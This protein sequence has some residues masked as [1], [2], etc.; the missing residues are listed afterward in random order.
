MLD[1]ILRLVAE[2]GTIGVAVIAD[3]LDQSP[4]LVRSALEE[5]AR[6][7]YLQVVAT[8]CAS[9]CTGCPSSSACLFGNQP[10]IWSLTPKGG[11]FVS[12]QKSSKH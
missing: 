2:R 6:Q 5:L 11:R 12:S 7:G 8:G 4:I 10:R 3:E 9:P 1:R